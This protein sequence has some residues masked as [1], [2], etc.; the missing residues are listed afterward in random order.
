MVGL[1]LIIIGFVIVMVAI[2][3]SVLKTRGEGEA[4]AGGV[5][6]IGPI[7]IILGTDIQSAKWVMILALVLILAVFFLFYYRW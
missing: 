6:F 5:I 7:P 3:V 2:A 1:F 4:R